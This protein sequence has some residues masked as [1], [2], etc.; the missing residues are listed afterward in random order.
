MRRFRRSVT[1]LAVGLAALS[2]TVFSWADPAAPEDPLEKWLP[3]Y[4]VARCMFP[5]GKLVLEHEGEL[6][7]LRPGD[8]LPGRPEVRVYAIDDEQAVLLE[9]AAADGL[10]SAI[11]RRILKVVPD[12]AG[13]VG[14]TVLSAQQ[15]RADE[16]ELFAEGSSFAPRFSP[17]EDERR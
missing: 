1:P 2:M 13:A 9:S 3:G 14:V 5:Q 17:D 11:P 6:V 7:V 16:A 10:A 15:P 4:R 8:R 12:P